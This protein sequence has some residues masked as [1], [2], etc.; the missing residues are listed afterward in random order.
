MTKKMLEIY[1][2]MQGKLS[3]F[4]KLSG[5]NDTE[6]AVSILDELDALQKEYDLCER[7]FKAEKHL[8][9]LGSEM[10]PPESE[11]AKSSGF[12]VIAKILRKE[13]L[14]ET[15][16]A[17]ITGANAVSGENFLVPKDVSTSIVELR[18]SYIS[19][20]G[21]VNVIPTATLSGSYTFE[22]GT[23]EGLVTFADG[24]DVPEGKSPTFVTKDWQIGLLGKIIPISNILSLT[25][26]A[27]L[28]AYIDTWFVKNAIISE[29]KDIFICL[30][31]DKT[32]KAL[33]GWEALKTSINI[34]LD[35]SCRVGGVI[36][37]N[38]SGFNYLDSKT[39]A[40]G[41]PILQPNPAMATQPMFQS[42]PIIYF[43]D[44]VLP[45]EANGFPIFYGDTKAGCWFIDLLGYQFNAS[46]HAGFTKNRTLLRVIE[47]YA[48][49][50]ADKDAYC[51]GLLKDA[52]PAPPK[53]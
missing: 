42:L 50:G 10:E 15:E 32:V 26:T 18:K 48:V 13:N 45:N 23:P 34:D 30:K 16:K 25:E 29:N 22:S 8:A 1:Q 14:D 35:P 17:L 36:V 24:D 39:D 41:R 9:L 31:K 28:T 49:M 52:P 27:G 5:E 51:Y 2:K 19:A 53:V 43:P 3:E 12:D 6:K 40:N 37:T 47:G 4:D 33:T 7:S 11:K 38:Q 44:T 20:K 21:I 46:E